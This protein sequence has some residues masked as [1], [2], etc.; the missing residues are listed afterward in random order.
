MST[1]KEGLGPA[2]NPAS[3]VFEKVGW[4][5]QLHSSNQSFLSA[6]DKSSWCRRVFLTTDNLSIV[7]WDI[8]WVDAVKMNVVIS[9]NPDNNKRILM[10][11]DWMMLSKSLTQLRAGGKYF[12]SDH[13]C[14]AQCDER[15]WYWKI[16][17]D[18]PGLFIIVLIIVLMIASSGE[19]TLIYRKLS[20]L[21]CK[22]KN[23]SM[24]AKVE[25]NE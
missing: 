11:T 24:P 1:Q 22:I 19:Q 25:N 20:S 5:C 12:T 2:N 23:M 4:G 6:K 16:I 7:F 17:L 18:N 14:S 21:A 15:H 3:D 13:Q 10:R 8:F 9:E